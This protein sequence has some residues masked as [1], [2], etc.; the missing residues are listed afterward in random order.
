MAR[1]IANINGVSVSN[2]LMRSRI[3][4]FRRAA[5]LSNMEMF[6]A[7]YSSSL[8]RKKLANLGNPVFV[9]SR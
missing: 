4:A 1:E 9:V 7:V 8:T 5:V 2:S 6:G 3:I